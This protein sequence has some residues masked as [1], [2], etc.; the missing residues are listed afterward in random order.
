MCAPALC[1]PPTVLTRSH[2]FVTGHRLRFVSTFGRTNMPF[3]FGH[4]R[5]VSGPVDPGFGQ[6]GG[7]VDPGYGIGVGGHPGHDLPEPPPGIWPPLTASNPIAPVPP[8]ASTKPPPGAIWPPPGRPVHPDAG[9][10]G[11]SGGVVT[12]PIASATYWM[13]AYCPSLGWRYVTVDPSL[14][15]GYPLPPAAQPRRS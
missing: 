6:P 7:P 5:E 11:G 1:A 3:Y 15:V 14:D 13:I 9:L 8:E 10:P 2:R 4:L 12:P